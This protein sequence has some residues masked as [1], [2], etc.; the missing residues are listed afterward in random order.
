MANN[1]SSS[2]SSSG[3]IGF[4]GALAI[5]FIALKLLGYIDWSW[6]WVL[7]PLW[8]GFAI[9]LVLVTLVVGGAG[10]AIL[11]DDWRDRRRRI[12]RSKSRS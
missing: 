10:I 12:E 5:L 6:W 1:V 7:S 11:I 4:C 2:S 8:I 9:A 3:G